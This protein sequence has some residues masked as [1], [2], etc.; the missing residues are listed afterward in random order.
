MEPASETSFFKTI[1]DPGQSQKKKTESLVHHNRRPVVLK[2][3]NV[4]LIGG[5]YDNIKMND[6][7]Q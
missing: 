3:L 2:T 5:D 4:A 7:L 6:K 1:L